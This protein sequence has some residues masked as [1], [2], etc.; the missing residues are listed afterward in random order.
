M[1]YIAVFVFAAGAFLT[2][3]WFGRSS[4]ST[5]RINEL[6]AELDDLPVRD[7]STGRYVK[8]P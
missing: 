6:L 1:E 4:T 8:R 2:G 5:K 3:V 7:P